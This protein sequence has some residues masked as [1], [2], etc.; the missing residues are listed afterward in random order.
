MGRL[1]RLD[2]VINNTRAWIIGSSVP[3]LPGCKGR[4]LGV[5]GLYG[6]YSLPPVGDGTRAEPRQN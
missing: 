2:W 6:G 4:S 3:V 5:A 1:V